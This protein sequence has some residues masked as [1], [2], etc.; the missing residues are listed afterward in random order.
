M[1]KQSHMKRMRNRS[2]AVMNN[3]KLVGFLYILMRD[4]LTPGTLEKIMIDH[5]DYQDNKVY[6]TNGW[7]AKYSEDIA[8][9]LK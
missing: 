6:Y 2:G 9:R 8:K 4:H 7:L 3:S 1:N 5:I